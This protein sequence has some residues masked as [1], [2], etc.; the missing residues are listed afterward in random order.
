[1]VPDDKVIRGIGN[2]ANEGWEDQSMMIQIRRFFCI[3]YRFSLPSATGKDFGMVLI[4]R[5]LKFHNPLIGCH[6]TGELLLLGDEDC[7]VQLGSGD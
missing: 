2:G 4:D 6:H 1:M 3:Q 7:T 5:F